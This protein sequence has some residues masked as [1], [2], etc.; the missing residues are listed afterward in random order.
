MWVIPGSKGGQKNKNK[1]L[2]DKEAFFL[3]LRLRLRFANYERF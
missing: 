1:N 3:K 2:P